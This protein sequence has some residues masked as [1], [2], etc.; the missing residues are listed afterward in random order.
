MPSSSIK[1]SV[2]FVQYFREKYRGALEQLIALLNRLTSIEATLVVVDNAEPGTWNHEVTAQLV[3]IGGDNSCHEFSAFERG[4]R[5]LAA[6]KC[7]TDV[8]AFVTDAFT[9]YGDRY[10]DLIDTETI[11]SCL[12]LEACIG[13]TD[14]F[15]PTL[16]AL[17]YDYRCWMRTSLFFMPASVLP[18]VVPICTPIEEAR[19]FGSDATMP[20]LEN[21]DLS[22]SLRQSILSWLTTIPTEASGVD[23][24]H[25]QFDLTDETFERFQSKVCAILREHLLSAKLQRLDIPYFDIRLIAK[26]ASRGASMSAEER[27]AWQWLGWCDA[28]PEIPPRYHLEQWECPALLVHGHP[29]EMFLLGWVAT[30]P[31]VKEVLLE[32][33]DY[34]TFRGS[35]DYSRSDVLEVYPEYKNDLCGFEI[36]VPI[37]SLVPGVYEITFRVPTVEIENRLGHIQV[38]PH[39]DFSASRL[40]LPERAFRG[41][42]I[43]ISIEGDLSTS[44]PLQEITVLWNGRQTELNLQYTEDRQKLNGLHSY[45]ISVFGAVSLAELSPQQNLE[46]LFRMEE[47]STYSWQRGTSISVDDFPPHS[48]SQRRVGAYNPMTR[49]TAVQVKGAVVADGEEESL[50]FYRE[51]RLLWQETLDHRSGLD[52]K[53]AW[54]ELPAELP[55]IPPGIAELSLAL[56]NP[57]GSPRVLDSWTS[58]VDY[59]VPFL[60]VETLKVQPPQGSDE[61]YNLRLSGWVASQGIGE[62]ELTIDGTKIASVVLDLLRPDIAA[63]FG[64]AVSLKQ[65]FFVNESLKQEPGRHLLQL[66]LPSTSGAEAE[67][68]LWSQEVAFEQAAGAIFRVDS[69]DLADLV[70]GKE[71]RFWSSICIEGSVASKLDNL[72]AT[73]YVEHKPLDRHLIGPDGSFFLQNCPAAAGTYKL[74]V[75]FDSNG[76]ALYD[77]G[78]VEAIFEPSPNYES[79]VAAFEHFIE[80]FELEGRLGLGRTHH[81][82]NLLLRRNQESFSSYAK[83][84]RETESALQRLSQWETKKSRAGASSSR[85]K[86]EHRNLKRSL[87]VL[88]ASWEVPCLRHGGGVWMTNLLKELSQRHEI[89]VVYPYS[90][91]EEGWIEDVRPYAKKVIGVGKSRQQPLNSVED[92][93][94]LDYLYQEYVPELRTAIESELGSGR[95]DIIDYQYTAMFPYISACATPKVLTVFEEP[96]SAWL[97][98]FSYESVPHAEKLRRLDRLLRIFYLSAV[99]LPRTF[100]HLIAVTREDAGILNRFQNDTELHVNGIGVDLEVFKAPE[101]NAIKPSVA[102]KMIVFLGNYNHPPSVDAARYIAEKIFPQLQQQHKDIELA[103][104]GAYPTPEL[105]KMGQ[106]DGIR[107]TGFV[108]DHR[109]YL[110]QASAFVAP[111]FTGAGMRVKVLEAMACGVPVVATGLAMQGIDAVDGEHF[112]RAEN[113]DEFIEASRRCI[114]SP[115]DTREVGRRGRELIAESYSSQAMARE[116]EAIWQHV[117]ADWQG[118]SA[119]SET[120]ERNAPGIERS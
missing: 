71:P 102:A 106:R 63:H 35:C 19:I 101:K 2:I 6:S 61:A 50:L 89:T 66:V 77:S 21:S 81:L 80:A 12:A 18:R 28:Q 68:V 99:A 7:E 75:V 103:I 48:L 72:Q 40:F 13:W 16:H 60:H 25:S 15:G 45:K 27:E 67:T 119:P 33:S 74:R 47:G 79:H 43:P 98:N 55:G 23:S 38:L 24:W 26:L 30:E 10:L 118:R 65:G 8:Y 97:A 32:L 87:R 100:P 94:I 111:I 114:E 108:D 104:V 112:F 117:I 5:Y 34:L 56:K 96:F 78:P 92:G 116:R 86:Q 91:H 37:A 4:L 41:R 14:S 11:Q 76:Q 84:L 54:F 46:L 49:R 95:Y 44:Y 64:Q 58:Q 70:E 115:D 59:F 1:L 109:P 62:L 42:D 113:A 53:L 83:M 107:V 82:I 57:Q 120:R 105:E 52:G 39:Y 29:A 17:G 73:L 20:F 93:Q 110:W 88:F 31:Q 90:A 36:R 9:A 85:M 3:H 69:A 51:D 22:P